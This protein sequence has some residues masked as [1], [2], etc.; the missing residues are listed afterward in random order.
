ME[1]FAFYLI[2][3]SLV[4]IF[5]YPLHWFYSTAYISIA[6]F[7]IL[8]YYEF[9]KKI[10]IFNEKINLK[11]YIITLA[12][13]YICIIFLNFLIPVINPKLDNQQLLENIFNSG[14]KIFIAITLVILAPI[15]EEIVF[16]YALYNVFKNKYAS[17]LISTSL[18]AFMH[19]SFSFLDF[20]IYFLIG[21][22][23]ASIFY[24]TKSLKLSIIAHIFNNFLSFLGFLI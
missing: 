15:L 9:Y 12:Y 24:Y 17:F 6:L 13:T 16:R 14:N 18:F 8:Y 5:I 2:I 10:C 21:S 19:S 7:G 11:K 4:A 3:Q 20:L 22:V 1:I 23:F